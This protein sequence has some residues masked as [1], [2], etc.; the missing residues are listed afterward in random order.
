MA[1]FQ[2]ENIEQ[3][4]GLVNL[5]S[6]RNG[7]QVGPKTGK[8]EEEVQCSTNTEVSGGESDVR[9]SKEDELKRRFL[10]KFAEAISNDKGD[11][12]VAVCSVALRESRGD[13]C[14]DGNVKV[15]LLVSRNQDFEQEDKNFFGTLERLLAAIGATVSE[16][17]STGMYIVILCGRLLAVDIHICTS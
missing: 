15:S 6:L 10:D 3:F 17:I 11:R 2:W 13:R 4:I 14:P 5:L 12:H 7:G 16:Q 1:I 9:E 8:E